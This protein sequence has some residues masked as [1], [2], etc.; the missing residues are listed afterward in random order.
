MFIQDSESHLQE[1]TD[2]ITNNSKIRDNSHSS[3]SS[4][5]TFVADNVNYVQPMLHS[6]SDIPNTDL[7]QECSNI[8]NLTSQGYHVDSGKSLKRKQ[9]NHDFDI[10]PNA[11]KAKYCDSTSKLQSPSRHSEKIS[12]NAGVLSEQ[13]F[14][15][16]APNMILNLRGAGDK[17]GETSFWRLVDD[18]P[19]GQTGER[20]DLVDP[21]GKMFK[22]FRHT[23]FGDVVLR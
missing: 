13:E 8:F 2:L 5:P 18:L 11:K 1:N 19:S 23:V 4:R 7:I 9:R 15:P 21:L 10:E 17:N 22:R 6:D 16:G 12:G 20:G 14:S 3:V